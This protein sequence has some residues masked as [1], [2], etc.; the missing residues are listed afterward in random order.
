MPSLVRVRLR[1]SAAVLAF[2]VVFAV[3]GRVTVAQAQSLTWGGAGTSDYFSPTNWS[4][5]AVAPPFLP[6]QSAVFGAGG[7]SAVVVDLS[8]S[9][10]FPVPIFQPDSWTFSANAQSVYSISGDA[11]AF[12]V[13]GPTGGI[14]NNA[15]AG[16]T[17]TIANNINDGFSGSVVP[18]MVQQLG[19]S[20]LVLAGANS[21]SGGTLI[22]A[23][24]LQ[25]TNANSLG[26]G[27]VIL[28][29]GT[30]QA[31]T[32]MGI[33]NNFLVNAP[34]GT[35]DVNGAQITL[36]G[37]IADGTGAGV[38][39]VIDSTGGGTLELSGLNT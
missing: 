18:V 39:S 13:A 32:S 14:I 28:N 36:S 10:V 23:G 26:A 5:P 29:G 16:Q 34:G 17:I 6:T 12:N 9:P 37:V 21:Y 8:H 35:V 3:A 24:T 2:G 15:N 27:N 22:S 1:R 4:N 31:A 20:T 19:N 11:I 33:G 30:L 38:L 7:S 25:V